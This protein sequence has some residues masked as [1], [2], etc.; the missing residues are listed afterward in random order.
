MKELRKNKD[1]FFICEE[2]NR[3]FKSYQGIR[4][5][6]RHSHKNMSQQDYYNKW[7][8]EE[9]D[10]K[11]KICGNK[12]K[13]ETLIHGYKFCCSEK[14]S[15]GYKYIKSKEGVLEKFGVENNF[16]REECKEKAKNTMIINHCVTSARKSKKIIEKTKR[17]CL[18]RYGNENYNNQE[19]SKQTCLKNNGVKYIFSDKE[20]MKKCI[21]K[22]YGV[23]NV[24]HDKTIFN[25]QQISGFKAKKFRDI[26]IYYR[27]S[28]ELDFL[29]NFYDK[30][31]IKQGLTFKYIFEN[32]NRIY[33]S[34]FYIPSKNLIIEIKSSYYFKKYNDLCSAKQK[35]CIK[36]GYMYLFI[37]DKNYKEIN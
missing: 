14:C 8:K 33:H 7:I 34:D 24:M 32:K 20:Y 4:N 23:E 19:K 6:I 2:C 18:E 5:H 9:K 30:I 12:T 16:Q 22:K 13:F 26:S 21:T 27:G 1:G 36:Q 28:Y 37:I 31:E 25:R 11:C 29:E 35:A 3:V 15:N 17:T 10:G